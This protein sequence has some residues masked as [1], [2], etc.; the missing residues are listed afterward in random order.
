VEPTEPIEL[1]TAARKDVSC[2]SLVKLPLSQNMNVVTLFTLLVSMSIF[3]V[4]ARYVQR[5]GEAP[6]DEN[7]CAKPETR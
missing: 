5:I 3:S 4:G 2:S 1:I 6:K 7:E